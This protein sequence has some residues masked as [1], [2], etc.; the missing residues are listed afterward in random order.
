MTQALPEGWSVR[1]HY[2]SEAELQAR[3]FGDCCTCGAAA[4][5]V[6]PMPGP[7]GRYVVTSAA[8]CARPAWGMCT[9][10]YGAY[11]EGPHDAGMWLSSD[12]GGMGRGHI[13]VERGEKWPRWRK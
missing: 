2:A 10:C 1:R 11:T 13:D 7:D 12:C 3:P 9:R 8:V 4:R 6:V 5:H